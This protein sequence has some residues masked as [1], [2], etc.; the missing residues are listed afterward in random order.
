MASALGPDGVPYAAWGIS[1]QITAALNS[2]FIIWIMTG[3]A[4][5]FFNIAFLGILPKS[6]PADGIFEVTETRP[7]SGANAV[8]KLLATALAFGFDCVISEWA[9]YLHRG[10]IRGRA[11]LENAVDI[12]AIGVAAANIKSNC[13]VLIS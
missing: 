3:S 7:L 11:M 8:A 1:L 6:S 10:C 5:T 12:E 2:A 9:I 4:P 13:A